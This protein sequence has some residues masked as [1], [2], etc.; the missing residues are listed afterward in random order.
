[1]CDGKVV[2]H[3]GVGTG[4]SNYQRGGEH[5]HSTARQLFARGPGHLLQLVIHVL[6]AAVDAL[7]KIHEALREAQKAVR[8]KYPE[9]YNWA[10]FVGID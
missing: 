2:F 7:E 8:N 4:K 6:E 5:Q 9:P 3:D 10:A 1:M